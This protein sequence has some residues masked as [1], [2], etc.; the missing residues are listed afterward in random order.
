M[1][2]EHW[3]LGIRVRLLI[4]MSRLDEAQAILEQM[5]LLD[6]GLEDPVIG[7]IEHHLQV[8]LATCLEQADKAWH[9]AEKVSQIAT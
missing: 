5:L 4:R 6:K 1:N 3:A 7:Q 8:E 9:Y 2:I